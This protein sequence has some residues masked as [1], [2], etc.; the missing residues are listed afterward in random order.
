MPSDELT[1]ESMSADKSP[2]NGRF[3]KRAAA[4]IKLTIHNRWQTPKE[5]RQF[6]AALGLLITEIVSDQIRRVKG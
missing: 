2:R 1:G 6:T 4:P 3:V 5:A